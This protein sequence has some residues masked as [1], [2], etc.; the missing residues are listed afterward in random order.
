MSQAVH[1]GV[2][3]MLVCLAKCHQPIAPFASLAPQ[4]ELHV[5]YTLTF[6]EYVCTCRHASMALTLSVH[7]PRVQHSVYSASSSSA[8]QCSALG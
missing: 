4:L 6:I 7:T 5:L 3:K 1:V 2:T 8:S